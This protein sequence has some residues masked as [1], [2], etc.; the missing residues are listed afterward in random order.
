MI[1][2]VIIVAVIWTVAMG[3]YILYR[4]AWHPAFAAQGVHSCRS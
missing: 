4:D 2:N 3:S 1:K